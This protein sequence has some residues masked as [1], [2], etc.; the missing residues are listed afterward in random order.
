MCMFT[1]G[2]WKNVALARPAWF[3]G[4]KELVDFLGGDGDA[5]ATQLKAALSKDGDYDP[6][7]AQQLEQWH[8]DRLKKFG[9]FGSGVCPPISHLCF[10]RLCLEFFVTLRI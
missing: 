10:L 6:A 7:Y 3:E 5:A 1:Q 8:R 9:L 2:R 4:F